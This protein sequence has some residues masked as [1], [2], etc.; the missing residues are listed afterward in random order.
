M[1]RIS[2]RSLVCVSMI[3]TQKEDRNL[4]LKRWPGECMKRKTFIQ[5]SRSCQKNMERISLPM[6]RE[7]SANTVQGESK[8]W[9]RSR[10][11]GVVSHDKADK[12]Y[13]EERQ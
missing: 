6:S 2:Y 9:Y 4:E 1:Y 5:L 13:I 10:K 8:R 3:K 12:I 11:Q 7:R